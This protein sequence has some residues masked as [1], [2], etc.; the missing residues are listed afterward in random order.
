[1]LE[2]GSHLRVEQTVK[3]EDEEA[4]GGVE[5][6]EH[7]LEDHGLSVNSEHPKD[8]RGSQ[9]G[10]QHCNCLHSQLED[11]RVSMQPVVVSTDVGNDP[12][13]G[14][15]DPHVDHNDEQ[16]RGHKGPDGA[17]LHRQPAV[18]I[19]PVAVLGSGYSDGTDQEGKS[20]RESRG[21]CSSLQPFHSCLHHV[22]SVFKELS[23]E[24]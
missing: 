11:T 19:C 15:E 22:P 14:D 13:H 21:P 2:G 4:L 6:G 1:M 5:D 18:V 3:E 20:C 16:G 23:T 17:I 8:P 24:Y 12:G 10:Q 9:D 7:I